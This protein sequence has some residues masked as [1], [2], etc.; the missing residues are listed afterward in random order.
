M[1]NNFFHNLFGK[2]SCD[3]EENLRNRDFN[4]EEK[5]MI[6]GIVDLA[7]KTAKDIMVPRTD[8]VFINIDM[9]RKE[10]LDVVTESGYSRFPVYEGTIDNV[11]GIL[12]SKDIL[13]IIVSGDNLSIKDLMRKAY[14]IPKTKKINALFHEFRRKKVHIAVVVDEY[15][16]VS[17][18]IC[19][20]DILEEIV[21]DIQ[22]EFDDD[23]EDIVKTGPGTYLCDTRIDIDDLNEEL[24]I[25]LPHDDYDTLGGFIFDL[26]GKI[27]VKYEKIAYKGMNFIIQEADGSK[28]KSVKIETGRKEDT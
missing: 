5:D 10:M 9:E 7:E 20:E 25:N 1:K 11:I 4:H 27:P 15:G 6:K 3:E 26:F 24:G 12:Y 23:E 18:I 16:G 19:L 28:I 17:G 22:D 14:F 2:K 13:R 8:V 21:G